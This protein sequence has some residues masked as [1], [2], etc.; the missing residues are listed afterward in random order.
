MSNIEESWPPNSTKISPDS[1][2][3]HDKIIK[4]I[5]N[6][7]ETYIFVILQHFSFVGDSSDLKFGI[8]RYTY[9]DTNF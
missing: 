1:E 7:V 5:D 2:I 6:S 4:S 9:L 3:R 8:R